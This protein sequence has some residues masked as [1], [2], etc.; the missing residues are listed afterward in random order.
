VAT[1]SE[2][3]LV[4]A[5]EELL[6]A[7]NKASLLLS[8]TGVAVGALLSGLIAGSWEP[9]MLTGQAQAIWWT[10]AL[11]VATAIALLGRAVFPQTTIHRTAPSGVIA[12]YGD[13]VRVGRHALRNAIE[14]GSSADAVEDQLFTVSLLVARK[15]SDIR[16][17]MILLA[18]GVSLVLLSLTLD[19]IAMGESGA[20]GSRA[21]EKGLSSNSTSIVPRGGTSVEC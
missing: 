6:R 20:S 14:K 5:R 19:A 9:S 1:R 11:C 21:C 12:Y 18:V 7:D 15:Y 2:T 13:V 17:A 16:R 3:L 4:Q 10:A 8:A